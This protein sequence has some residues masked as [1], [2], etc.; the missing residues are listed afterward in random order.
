MIRNIVSIAAAT[1]MGF[2]ILTVATKADKSLAQSELNNGVIVSQD[3][4]DLYRYE[5]AIAVCYYTERS[6]VCN[7][8]KEE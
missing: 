8:K 7:F 5:D 2:T 4:P 1:F 3:G 6:L